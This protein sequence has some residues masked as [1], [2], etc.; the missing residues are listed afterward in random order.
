MLP[1]GQGQQESGLMLS[2]ETILP[3]CLF[4]AALL[5]LSLHGLAASGH[6]PRQHRSSAPDIRAV[7]L[8]GSIMA[9]AICL[10]VALSVAWLVIPWPVAVIGGGLAILVAPLVLQQ[11][12]DRFVDG[13]AGLLSFAGAGALLAALLVVCAS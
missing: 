6:F 3:F 12:P 4:L 5:A 11:F 10:L 2:M 8:Y 9:A 7:V 1:K 13:H